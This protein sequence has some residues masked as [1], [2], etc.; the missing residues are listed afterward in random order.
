MNH[1]K[2]PLINSYSINK[3]F[4]EKNLFEKPVE[5]NKKR[6]IRLIFWQIIIVITVA[7]AG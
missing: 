6:N 5:I 1:E 3:D 2:K 4:E 7:V